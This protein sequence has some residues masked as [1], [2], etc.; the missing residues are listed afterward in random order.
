[1]SCCS[2]CFFHPKVFWQIQFLCIFSCRQSSYPGS[3][4]SREGCL[5][6]VIQ[7]LFKVME[8]MSAFTGVWLS[9]LLPSDSGWCLWPQSYCNSHPCQVTVEDR[10]RVK[11]VFCC[12][13]VSDLGGEGNEIQVCQ[14]MGLYWKG[15]SW[16]SQERSSFSFLQHRHHFI[17]G[18]KLYLGLKGWNM[19]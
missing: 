17:S 9:L 1:M 4:L 3:Y 16:C 10:V 15:K 7:W 2:L 5:E 13:R 12:N 8:K 14:Q 6:G 19:I 11:M 18:N